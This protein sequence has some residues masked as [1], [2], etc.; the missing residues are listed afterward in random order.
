MRVFLIAAA[1]WAAAP[2]SAATLKEAAGLVQIRRA[3]EDTWRPA[4]PGILVNEGD[5]LRTGFNARALVV[6][7]QGTKVTAAGNAHVVLEDDRAAK[8]LAYLLFGAVRVDAA[9]GGGRQASL[10]T[11]VATLRARSDRAAFTAAVAGGGKTVAD[12]LDGLVGAEDNRGASTLLK[13]GQRLEAD[14]RGLREAAAS[15]TPARA[16]KEDFAALM[17]RELGFDLARDASLERAASETRRA[18][19]ELGR[20]LTDASGNRVRAESWVTRPSAS[21]VKLVT[22]NQ[23]PG[24]LHAFAWAGQFDQDLPVDL[25]PVL[26]SL[27][28]SLD[29]A[30]QFTLLE[31]QALFTNGPDRLLERADGGH[32]VDLNSNPD[33]SDDVATGGRPFFYTLFDRSGLY[34]NGV[35]KRGWTGAN[36]QEENDKV[37]ASNNDPFT[38]AALA[39]VLPTSQEN[40]TSPE[41]GRAHSARH[42]EFSD[43]TI[44]DRSERWLE[45]DGGTAAAPAHA[46]TS[47]LQ[48]TVKASEWSG[49]SIEIIASGRI[50]VLTRQLP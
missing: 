32:Q 34:V 37:Q 46:S 38:G 33:P 24:Q 22:V 48:F 25:E 17:R 36:I 13:T 35:L 1:L 29:A 42:E 9:L 43:G 16:R 45:A 40:Y 12:V 20:L 26:S 23:R 31:Y 47:E 2:V 6:T 4:R 41:A 44:L 5:A 19:H 18:E 14:M 15:P 28:G 11:P 27:S 10:R 30:S 3:G 8:F 21:S 7:T 50:L 39:T 49:R